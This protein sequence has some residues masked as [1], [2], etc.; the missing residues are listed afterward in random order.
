MYLQLNSGEPIS[1]IMGLLGSRDILGHVIGMSLIKAIG[2]D[3]ASCECCEPFWCASKRIKNMHYTVEDY[4]CPDEDKLSSCDADPAVP[5]RL[6]DCWRVG[7][8]GIAQ[9]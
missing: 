1:F 6:P 9:H 3:K 8:I 2:S 5:C 7:A 4:A